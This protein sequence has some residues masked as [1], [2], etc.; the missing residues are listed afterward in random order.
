M[1]SLPKQERDRVLQ[2]L[3]V[4][5]ASELKGIEPDQHVLDNLGLGSAEAMRIQLK[6]WG[7]PES[8][9]EEMSGPDLT[10]APTPC[11]PDRSY[12]LPRGLLLYRVL[13]SSPP[14]VTLKTRQR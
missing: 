1:G 5:C 11:P 6:N 4:W 9:L 7:L 10:S 12:G 8:L 14:L 2:A 13:G 3:L